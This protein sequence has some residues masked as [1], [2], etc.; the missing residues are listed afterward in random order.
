MARQ[1]LIPAQRARSQYGG[2]K[3]MPFPYK[4]ILCPVDFDESSMGALEAAAQFAR[5]NDGTVYVFHVVPMVI[6]PTGMPVY[7]DLYKG[8]EETARDK[9]KEVARKR[10][11]GVKYE[12]M[13]HLGEPAGSIIKTERKIG[14]DL[15]VMATHGRRGFSRFVLGSVAELVLRE[16][17][18][19]VLTVRQS[20]ADRDK[21]SAW[22]TRNPVVAAPKEKLSV[23]HDKMTEGGFRAVPVVQDGKPIGIVTDRDIRMHVGY[24]EHT[25]A[26]KAMSEALITVTPE[27]TV[28][29]AARLMRERK[30]GALP[31]IEGDML[32]GLVT[33]TDVLSALTAE[34]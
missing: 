12:L 9:L 2:L 4:R 22:M 11:S 31:V 10:L 8:Q 33:T 20:P 32:V 14:A 27:T 23:I 28:R 13:T 5:Q 21:V 25:E 24:L 18:C 34:D 26:D 15:I 6:P 29:E 3:A 1:S 17:K 19:P 30:I 16:A 7:V